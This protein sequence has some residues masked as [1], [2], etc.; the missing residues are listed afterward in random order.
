[1]FNECI[2]A[3]TTVLRNNIY[4]LRP[5]SFRLRHTLH[6]KYQRPLTEAV[7]LQQQQNKTL[8]VRTI[9][10]EKSQKGWL[11]M[12]CSHVIRCYNKHYGPIKWPENMIPQT[13]TF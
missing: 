12:P 5:H 6:V 10:M 7:C 9:P 8:T 2:M 3:S 13:T 4:P 1:M 11:W